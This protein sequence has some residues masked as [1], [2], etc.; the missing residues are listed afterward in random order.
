MIDF[1]E[2]V[3]VS[4]C[5]MQSFTWFTGT[6]HGS[7]KGIIQMK[8]T[9]M[10]RDQKLMDRIVALRNVTE[11]DGCGMGAACHCSDVSWG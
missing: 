6:P 9:K 11:D 2:W 5:E 3:E 7:I 8:A 1:P 10:V 4:P